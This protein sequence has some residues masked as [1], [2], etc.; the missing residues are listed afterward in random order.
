MP[1]ETMARPASSVDSGL[2]SRHHSMVAVSRRLLHAMVRGRRQPG[3]VLP[4]INTHVAFFR[5]PAAGEVGVF[6]V[7]DVYNH[8][9]I[10]METHAD[11]T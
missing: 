3:A 6:R 8:D 4:E 1:G 2:P 5:H 9:T 7:A 10:A 11:V